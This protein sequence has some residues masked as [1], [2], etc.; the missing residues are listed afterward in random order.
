VAL[1]VIGAI[2][3]T[4]QREAAQALG[5]SMLLFFGIYFLAAITVLLWRYVTASSGSRTAH[6]L[7]LMLISVIVVL[8]LLPAYPVVT[9]IWLSISALPN[10]LPWEYFALAVVTLIP[11]GFSVA[12]VR[13]ARSKGRADRVTT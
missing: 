13:S 4:S 2:I 3:I 7:R 5:G 1:V 6:G 12:V 9:N 8:A 11:I 10:W